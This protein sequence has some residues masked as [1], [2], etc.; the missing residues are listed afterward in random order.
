MRRDKLNDGAQPGLV[1]ASPEQAA[2]ALRYGA[3]PF[4][5]QRRIGLA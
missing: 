3:L 1:G 2:A 5:G 4:G